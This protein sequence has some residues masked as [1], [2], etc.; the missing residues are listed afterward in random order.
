MG[1]PAR[2]PRRR[3]FLDPLL[4]GGNVVARDGSAEDGVDELEVLTAAQGA[5]PDPAVRELAV[6]ARLL[7]VAA[8]S[9]RRALDR[10]PVG[11]L[12][13][14][15]V[16][17]DLVTLPQ[18]AHDDLDMELPVAREQHLVGL[19]V[20]RD[21]E[22]QVLFHQPLECAR[23]LVL[24]TPRLWLDREGGR[25]L[26]E[27]HSGVD[28]EG[29]LSASV[30]PVWVSLSLATAPMSPA[31]ISGT[32]VGCFPCISCRLPTRSAMSRDALCTVES[33]VSVP[34]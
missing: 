19:R 1:K 32:C 8:M 25:R 22:N 24:V 7:L 3:R 14:L 34:E 17:L 15:E 10:L 26:R 33:A 2:Y 21:L 9:L 23:D 31:W 5:H 18:P 30:S 11:D 4:D 28:D 13:L 20:A 16:D 29:A 6:A 27:G 12:G